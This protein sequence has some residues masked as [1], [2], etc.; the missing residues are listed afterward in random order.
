MSDK[1][2]DRNNANPPVSDTQDIK[3]AG[4][5]RKLKVNLNLVWF[6]K[7][8]K[9]KIK[10]PDARNFQQLFGSKNVTQPLSDKNR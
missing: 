1:R 5:L 3:K 4:I 6:K 10:P 7:K 9:Y 8:K 2:E